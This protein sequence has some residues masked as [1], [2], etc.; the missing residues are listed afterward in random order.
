LISAN[1]EDNVMLN[2]AVSSDY[3]LPVE[4]DKDVSPDGYIEP[5]FDGEP[6]EE[7]VGDDY[8][9]ACDDTI[10]VQQYINYGNH[11]QRLDSFVQ[12]PTCLISLLAQIKET[13][14]ME[15]SSKSI[16]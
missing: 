3:E 4:K 2:P 7:P 15:I 1:K 6:K 8:L 16:W 5:L 13:K 9:V 14:V 11:Y 12:P 10:V